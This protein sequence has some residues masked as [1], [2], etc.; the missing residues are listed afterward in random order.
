MSDKV[1]HLDD[2]RLGKY[3]KRAFRNWQ[4]KFGESFGL[5]TTIGQISD[6]TLVFLAEGRNRSSFYLLDLI[7][8]VTGVGSAFDFNE[9]PP[10][11][12]IAV[13][14]R[15][16]FLLDLIRYEY[17]KRLGWLE[18]YPGDECTLVELVVDFESLAPGL[19]AD[20][21]TLS[22]NHPAYEAFC[23]ASTMEKEELIRKLIPKA[24]EM[25]QESSTTL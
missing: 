24:L 17:M 10:K 6:K 2:A 20:T 12:Q 9:L 16:L 25:I 4:S 14:D 11:E 1:I 18:S 3:A 19:R 13:M 15:H 21:P 7:M 22:S 8:N 5:A 23:A